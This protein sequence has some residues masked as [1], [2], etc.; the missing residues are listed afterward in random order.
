MKARQRVVVGTRGSP[1]ALVQTEEVLKQLRRHHPGL[2]FQVVTIATRPDIRREDPLSSFDRGMFVKELEWALLDREVDLVVHSLKDLPAETPPQFAIA[3][4]GQR[5]DPR[6][7]L[8]SR[9]GRTLQQLPAGARVGTSS[10]RRECQLKALRRDIR[11]VPIRGNVDTRLRKVLQDGQYDAV[12][13]AA[14]GIARLGML[15]QVTQYF[16]TKE[17]IPPPGQAALAVETRAD[18]PWA[19]QIVAVVN[20]QPTA[21]AVAAERGFMA[22]LGSGCRMP[23]AAYGELVEGRLDLIGLISDPQG[24]RRFTAELHGDPSRPEEAGVELAERLLAMGGR[25]LVEA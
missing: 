15:D 7:V 10:P 5:L 21:V 24:E 6:D 20:H 14:A 1:L 18:D 3:A 22:R 19:Q 23:F 13:L 25:D 17:I 4:I 16:S 8:V 2:E 11:V 12:V 9:D